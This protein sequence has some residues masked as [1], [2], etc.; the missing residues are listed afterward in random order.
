MHCLKHLLNKYSKT[1]RMIT[2]VLFAMSLGVYCLQYVREARAFTA[3]TWD[4]GGTTN[5]WSEAANWSG[6]TVPVAGDDVTFDAT[7]TKSVTIDTNINVGS[8]AIAASY[9]GTIT[10]SNAASITVTGCSGR[11]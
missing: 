4:G 5:N 11:V 1:T 7:S 9:T 10:Q 2:V 3:K 6:D 8:I